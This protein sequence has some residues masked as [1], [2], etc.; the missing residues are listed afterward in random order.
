M[1]L[2]YWGRMLQKKTGG[3]VVSRNISRSA[4]AAAT[5]AL[6]VAGCGSSSKHS[7][8]NTGSTGSTV[9]TATQSST[10]TN[11]ATTSG[12]SLSKAQYEA[13]LAPLL[14]DRVG[15]ALR[16]ALANGG[17]ANPQ[18]LA[19]AISLIRQAHD[20]MAALNPPT[21]IA[22]LHNQA[23]TALGALAADMSKMRSSLQANDKSALV[24]AV[25]TVERDALKI[26]S[27]GSQMS[28]RGF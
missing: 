3:Y 16:S 22:D 11:T 9:N 17:A 8:A 24:V 7:S 13:K 1:R 20:A 15:P 27:I 26:E 21:Q 19:T 28:A 10:T 18:K 23:V 12:Q 6:A 4:V 5:I 2:A 25:K 14:N